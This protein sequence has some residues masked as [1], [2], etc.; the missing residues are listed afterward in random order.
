MS[1]PYGGALFLATS[2]DANDNMFLVVYGVMSSKNSEDWNWFLQKLKDLIGDKN[3]IILSYRHPGL[4]HSIPEIFG[5]EN[6]V[7]IIVT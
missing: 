6:H 7:I 5:G 2:Y 1:G 3:V 4:Q